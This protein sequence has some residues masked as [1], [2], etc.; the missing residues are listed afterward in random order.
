MLG[1]SQLKEIQSLQQKKFRDQKKRFI[2]E[3]IKSVIELIKMHPRNVEE[4]F[5]TATFIQA[6]KQL[7]LTNT[8]KYSE[9]SPD[10]LSRISLQK[11]PNNVLAVCRYFERVNT[12]FDFTKHFTFY[13]DEIRDPGNFGTILRVA[14]W[15]GISTVFCSPHACDLYNPKVVQAS[16]G[17]FLRVNVIYEELSHLMARANITAVYGAVLNGQNIY[18]LKLTNGLIVIGNEANGITLQNLEHIRTPLSIPAHSQNGTESLNAAMAASI[19][20]SEF[21]RQLVNE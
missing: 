13:L 14:D 4:V 20:A 16:M 7:L 5:A 12:G 19:I 8:I 9:I 3:G 1:K 21:F 6:N 10:E 2:V 18:N 17:A 15:Y 11:N